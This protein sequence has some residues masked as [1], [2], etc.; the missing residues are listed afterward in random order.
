MKTI[1]IILSLIISLNIFSQTNEI[2]SDYSKCK[3]VFSTAFSKDG[4]YLATAVKE[5]VILW[6]INSGKII[7][8]FENKNSWTYGDPGKILFSSDGKLISN[9]GR[10]FCC[11]LWD[12]NTGKIIAESGIDF[13]NM[14]PFISLD[15]KYFVAYMYTSKMTVCNIS[16]T[17][18]TYKSFD[19]KDTYTGACINP[20]NGYLVLCQYRMGNRHSFYM[21]NLE[22]LQL[23]DDIWSSGK[24]IDKVKIITNMCFSPNGKYLAGYAGKSVFVYNY[25]TGILVNEIKHSGDV[26][27]LCFAD[28]NKIISSS[29]GNNLQLWNIYTGSCLLNYKG[30]EDDIISV[31]VEPALKYLIS[32]DKSGINKIFAINSSEEIGTLQVF[33]NLNWL[34]ETR[35]NKYDCTEGVANTLFLIDGKIKIPINKSEKY[36]YAAGVLK[37]IFFRYQSN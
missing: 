8:L 19:T 21:I 31:S 14:G 20:R 26:F 4:K 2:R 15:N 36:H 29:K 10:G 9:G 11:K 25:E 18:T 24:N 28:T 6:D 32:S 27:S 22:T 3:T 23:V 16:E 33:S 30:H 13:G 5:G 17:P 34:L 37:E 12:I 35:N 7:K 1:A